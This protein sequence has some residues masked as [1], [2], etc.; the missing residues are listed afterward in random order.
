MKGIQRVVYGWTCMPALIAIFLTASGFSLSSEGTGAQWM[1]L[2]GFD[3]LPLPG[4]RATLETLTLHPPKVL[5]RSTYRQNPH[6]RGQAWLAHPLA[7]K[8]RSKTIW[9]DGR[10]W[11]CMGPL[12]LTEIKRLRRKG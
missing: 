6:S 5:L 1:A 8:A 7:R 11:T 9:T 10:P 2:A 4:G 12:M 3:Q